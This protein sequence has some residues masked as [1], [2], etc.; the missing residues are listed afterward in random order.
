MKLTLKRINL[1][2]NYTS[3]ELYIDNN[4]FCE[5]L[6]DPNRDYNKNG[7]FDNE[8]KKIY[9]NTCIPYGIYEVKVS[10][11]PKFKRYLPEILNVNS[12]TGIRIHR[13]NY[14]RDTSGCILVGEKVENGVLKN[15]TVYETQL[16]DIIR[17]VETKGEK[18]LLEIL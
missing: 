5:T 17:K 14:V 10:Y 12:F 9:G 15:S 11:S 13:G 6:E 4:Y 1:N 16:T 7:I 18:V 3:G 8:E 2:H